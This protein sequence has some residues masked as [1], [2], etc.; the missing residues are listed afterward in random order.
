MDPG[1]QTTGKP[2]EPLRMKKMLTP[3]IAIV[4]DSA[5]VLT[6]RL[7]TL[8]S[9]VCQCYEARSVVPTSSRGS[10]CGFGRAEG[11][12]QRHAALASVCLLGPS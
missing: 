6:P 4:P 7:R 3:L 9:I 11:V 5:S 10:R 1:R 8:E 2:F 12:N